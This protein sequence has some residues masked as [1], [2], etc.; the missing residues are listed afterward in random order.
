[1][2]P[3]DRP[4]RRRQWRTTQTRIR[5]QNADA[6]PVMRRRLSGVPRA[7]SIARLTQPGP[8]ARINP[9]MK[10][11]RPTPTTMS[12]M[13]IDPIGPPLLGF[14]PDEESTGRY[15][16]AGAFGFPLGSP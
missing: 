4:G 15:C 11:T 10:K 3:F 1:M 12:L 13:A 9:S 5:P 14:A 7:L 16:A 2:L 8:A 6:I